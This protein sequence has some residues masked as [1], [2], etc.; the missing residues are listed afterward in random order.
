MPR[1]ETAWIGIAALL[2]AGGYFT[3]V[4]TS[5]FQLNNPDTPARLATAMSFLII[6]VGAAMLGLKAHVSAFM[7]Q[8]V[9]WLSICLAGTIVFAYRA[10][11]QEAI[12]PAIAKVLGIEQS[13]EASR[14]TNTSGGSTRARKPHNQAVISAGRGGQFFVEAMIEETHVQLMADT[15]ATYITLNAEDAY[16]IGYD[17][18]KLNFKYRIKTANGIARTAQVILD[19]VLIGQVSV[20]NVRASISEPGLL[21]ISLLGMSYLSQLS[22]FQIRGDQLV[23]KQ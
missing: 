7:R 20:R 19:E 18:E 2:A 23:L 3:V 5:G 4:Q 9:A 12:G 21:H 14:S 17:A 16:R 10:D 15:G 11:F 1:N 22:S 13:A 8:S 6:I